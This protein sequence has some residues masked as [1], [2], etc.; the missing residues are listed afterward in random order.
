MRQNRPA[1]S[2]TMAC[3][4]QSRASEIADKP[5]FL[6]GACDLQG[7]RSKWVQPLLDELLRIIIEFVHMTHMN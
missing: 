1:F 6:F 5:S 2:K 3:H 4:D 7:W